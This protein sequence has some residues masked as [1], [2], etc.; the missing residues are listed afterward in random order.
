MPK[1]RKVRFTGNRNVERKF[2]ELEER[3]DKVEA[4]LAPYVKRDAEEDVEIDEEEDE[5][6]D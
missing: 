6:E 3:L 2:D 5:H 4:F 1:G